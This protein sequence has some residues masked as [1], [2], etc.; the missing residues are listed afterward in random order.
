MTRAV[1]DL[2]SNGARHDQKSPTI[3]CHGTR[4]I[5][6]LNIEVRDIYKRDFFLVTL[7]TIFQSNKTTSRAVVHRTGLWIDEVSVALSRRLVD[8]EEL[9]SCGAPCL[10]EGARERRPWGN[11]SVQPWTAAGITGGCPPATRNKYPLAL[12]S[13]S[14]ARQNGAPPVW[15]ELDGANIPFYVAQC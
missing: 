14:L 5:C 10:Q 7:A 12:Q 6:T 1:P 2:T 15:T 13:A 11:Y 9:K 8:G 4:K 3:L